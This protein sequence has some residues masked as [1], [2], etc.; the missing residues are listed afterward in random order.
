MVGLPFPNSN[1]LELREKMAWLKSSRAIEA[2]GN[3]AASDYYENLCMRAVNQSIGKLV[4][5]SV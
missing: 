4:P 1:S 3:A 2:E 5:L